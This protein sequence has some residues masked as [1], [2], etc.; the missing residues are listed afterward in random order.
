M[1]F[2]FLFVSER[3]FTCINNDE[4][5]SPAYRTLTSYLQ[6]GTGEV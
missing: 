5:I 2:Y 6:L 1:D 3:I 4:I